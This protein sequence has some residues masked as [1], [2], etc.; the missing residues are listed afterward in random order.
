MNRTPLLLSLLLSFS[1]MAQEFK[2]TGK[3]TSEADP[4]GLPGVNVVIKGTTIGT[5]TDLDGTFAIAAPPEAVLIF[6]FIGYQTQEISVAAQSRVSVVMVEEA[7]TLGEVIVVGYSTIESQNLTGAVTTIKS[8]AVK[9]FAITGIDQALQGQAAGVQVTQSS[10][11]P[12]GGVKVSIRGPTSISAR[13]EPLY[14][15]DGIQVKSADLSQREYGGQNDNALSLLNPNDYESFTVLQDASAKALYGSRASNGVVVITTKRGKSGRAKVNFD[16]QR[17]IIDLT[18]TLD[19]LNAEQ[20]L[21]L[22]R[23][24]V[25]NAGLNPDALGLI[26]G[27]TDAVDTDWQDVVLRR[28]I[29]Q[30]YQMSA[31][32]GT[33]ATRF[34]I[35]ANLRD[36]E[37]VQFNNKFQRFST[38]LNFDQKINSK[39]NLGTNVTISRA[40]NKRVKGDN[41]LDGVYSGAIKSLP[42][43]V[44]YDENG[45]LVGPGSP[46]YPGFPNFNPLAQA[47]LPRFEV[48]T[49]KILGGLHLDYQINSRFALRAMTSVDF[50]DITEDNYES[51]QT[52]IGG[53]L[54]SVGGQGYGIFAASQYTT[55]TSNGIV[56]YNQS[57]GKHNISA[58]A[59]AELLQDFAN[60]SF[61]QGRLYPSDDFTYIA[62]AGLVDDGSSFRAAAHSIVSGLSDVR[63][64]YEDKYLFSASFRADASSNFGPNNRVG[65]FPG[66]SAGWRISK[67]GFFRSS[68][69]NDL[70][71]TGS[72]GYTGNERIGAFQ[73]LGTW[74][75]TSYSGASGT[76]PNGLNNPDVKWETTRELNMGVD[77]S[78]LESR[79]ELQLQAYQNKTTDLL[80]NRPL[81]STSG[82]TTVIDNIGSMSNTGIGVTVNTV[83]LNGG[84]VKWNTSFNISKNI[85]KVLELADT[86]P[87]FRGYSGEGVDATNIITVGHPLGTF[88]GLN[89]L[90]VNPA[91]GDAIYEDLNNDG[92]ISNADGMV[93]GN[94]QPDF[95]GGVTNNLS[96]KNFDLSV[97]INFSVGN[98]I[99][100]FTKSGLVNMGSDIESNQSTDALRRWKNEGDITD[101]P[102]YVYQGANNN[103]HSNRLLEDG[104]YLR[105]KNVSFGYNLPATLS[106]RFLVERLRLYFTATNLWTWTKYSGSDPEVSTLDGSSSAQG[107][108]FYTLP[109]VRTL[110]VGINATLK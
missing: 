96:Y 95:I 90:G 80:L 68:L 3:V 39:V 52:A 70:K 25:T 31:S 72:F 93:I 30:Q 55:M 42:F 1:I 84:P 103:L 104:S 71:M 78:I 100:N 45:F 22:Q 16:V 79:V 27:V 56:S 29:L 60:S 9:D 61:V 8:E 15:I 14:I 88:Y 62:S 58:L 34:Y 65:Y 107:I 38:T 97:F 10:G 83:N 5:I 92:L 81:P 89:F 24:A 19:L 99:L 66:F 33:E 74:G 91:T 73:Y 32:G 76:R 105:I 11:T 4:E 7:Q 26:P 2:V 87:L 6:S 40:L 47:L 110:A 36:E 94:A 21:E 86:I 64:D 51:S 108:D 28:G 57:F 106:H 17:G 18:H 35:S 101:V 98:Q 23:E 69:I 59:G 67:E 82:F 102:R 77:V 49:V 12:G 20:L 46:L 44:P 41:F 37:G 63:Y 85:N 13:N 54:Q 75:A 43:D 48:T 50:N 109:Q 53:F